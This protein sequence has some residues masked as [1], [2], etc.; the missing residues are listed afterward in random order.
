[1][2][3]TDIFIRRPSLSIVVNV[4]ILLAGL[5]AVNQLPLRQYPTLESATITVTTAYPGATP[6]L[7]QGFVTTPIAQSIATTTGVE[8]LTS[9]TVQGLSTIS[10]RLK[11]NADSNQAMTEIMAKINEVRFKLPSEATDPVIRKTSGD[12]TAVMYI[13]FSSPQLSI[14]QV[15][16]YLNRSVLPRLASVGGVGSLELY[17]AQELSIRM[18]L[19]PLRMAA[20][21][22]TAGDI[23]A[24]LAENNVQ[25]APGKI[26]GAYIS[27]N[28]TAD[29]DINNLDEF[30]ELVLKSEGD[31]FIRVKD[32]ATVEF[33]AKSDDQ[34]AYANGA[35]VVFVG[36]NAAPTGN[37]LTIVA[38]TN[39]LLAG[40]EGAF[41]PGLQYLVPYDVTRFINASIDK[42]VITLI[43]AILI[44]IVV[45]FLFLGSFRAIFVPIV[46]IPLSLIG[47]A[48]LMS[49]F[50]FS[51]NLLTLLAMIL[52]I[53]LVVDDAIVVVEN[54]FRHLEEGKTPMEASLVGAREIMRPVIAM[55]A[56][57]AI[58][59]AP[60]GMVGGLTG[61]LFQEF[62]F[63]LAAS[64][65]I[66]G[67]VALTLSPMMAA[68]TFTKETSEGWFAK[69]VEGVFIALAGH[70]RRLLEQVLKVRYFVV[71]FAFVLIGASGFMYVT[72]QQELAPE[73]DQGDVILAMKGP[74]GVNLKYTEAYVEKI[75]KIFEKYPEYANSFFINGP[76][77][78]EGFGGFGLSR[79]EDRD[80]T[81]QEIQ[82]QV[83]GEVMNVE[84]LA[85]YVFALPSLPGSTGGMPVQM[86]ISSTKTPESVY[87]VVEDLKRAAA[88][89]GLFALTDSTLSFNN[90]V[91]KIK[92]DRNKANNLGI[93]MKDISSTL[94]LLISENYVNRISIDGRAY[95]VI[96]Q[97]RADFRSTAD[98]INSFYVRTASGGQV[99]LS[100][101]VT[102]IDDVE[103]NKLFQFNQLNSTI[104][105]A[106]PL[107]GVAMDDVV[108][109]LENYAKTQFPAGFSYDWQ[110]ETRQYVQE[111]GQ[112]A[113][114]FVLALVFIYLALVVQ[115]NSFRDPL[116]ILV[117]VP[118]SIF[119]ALIPIYLGY[120]TV[121]IYTQIGLVTLVGLISK[122]GILMVEFANQ[123][124]IQEG[125]SRREAILKASSVRLRPILM[126]TA[127]MVVGLVPL[128]LAKGAGASS[129]FS[130]GIVIVVGMLVGTFF[131][132]FVLPSIYALLAAHH[133]GDE[134]ATEAAP[135]TIGAE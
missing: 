129:H 17:G 32:V 131:T 101:V 116:I 52:A 94:S 98:S 36:V 128:V 124:Q 86:I 125:F 127:A 6:E 119:G 16:D 122:H 99:P 68:Y 100:T 103:P 84:G 50:G 82:Q 75:Q 106:I 23:S 44:V 48:A 26:E 47:A 38:D 45:L 39:A 62:A 110:G 11:L 118:L 28:L 80:R 12:G 30:R 88:K 60:I 71:L 92:I 41:P 55:T 132:L 57:L 83:Q 46:T 54:V 66:S 49:M 91:T 58:V 96:P 120:T 7:M 9:D 79:W 115:F 8:Y 3:F 61:S 102:L 97:A 123:L 81:Q 24:A 77:A 108:R 130:L 117:S 35:P 112:L 63:A 65:V 74:Q 51:I 90:P 21:D 70:Y 87:Q 15:T 22:L 53:G 104:F 105:Q 64:V 33:G 107:P 56:T 10:A 135:Q 59:Y 13:G 133:N 34:S 43:E 40:M 121:N 19:D 1:M 114:A 2:T 14:P 78:N 31:R 69:K 25:S 27:T 126:T 20:H 67:V 29:T 93:R 37:P 73:E 4:V 109:Y 85:A 5:L 72:G 18:W 42:V 76:T 89:S 95:E 113:I 134:P 111:G